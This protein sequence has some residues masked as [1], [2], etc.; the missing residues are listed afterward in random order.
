MLVLTFSSIGLPGL[1]GF[2]GEV[3]ILLGM[4]QRSQAVA[5]EWQGPFLVM[6]VLA[7]AGVVLGAWYM[8]WLVQ[9]VFFGPLEEPQPPALPGVNPHGGGH[10][11]STSVVNDLGWR[12]RIALAPLVVFIVWIGVSPGTFLAKM[13]G[14]L[15][16]LTEPA[17]V[18]FDARYGEDD[19]MSVAKL[20]TGATR[21]ARPR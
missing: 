13:S 18:A 5:S 11:P 14:T 12:E 4:F 21:V 16:P 17:K 3:L 8:L 10:G 15:G 6:A 9:R 20:S 2:A 19:G 1:N 7:V